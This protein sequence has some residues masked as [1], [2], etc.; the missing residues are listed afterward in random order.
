MSLIKKTT[1][2]VSMTLL[3]VIV[4]IAVGAFLYH[5]GLKSYQ[6]SSLNGYELLG[7]LLM[8][9]YFLVGLPRIV[10]RI[11]S[12]WRGLLPEKNSTP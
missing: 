10:K 5:Y 4:T 12:L 9:F 7:T 2:F 11:I 8:L 6:T 3:T 1:F